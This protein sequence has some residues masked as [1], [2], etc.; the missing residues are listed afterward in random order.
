MEKNIVID[1]REVPFKASGATPRIY[2]R[3]FGKDI[4]ADM[5][6]LSSQI[7]KSGGQ[8]NVESLEVFENVMYCMAKQADPDIPDVD[9]WMDQFEFM[10]IYDVMP[11]IIELWNL[12][13]RQTAVPKKKAEPQSVK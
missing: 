5:Q 1:G 10:S 9:A 7:A 12:N 11:Q 2:R 8:L 6:S 3:M 13:E 4:F